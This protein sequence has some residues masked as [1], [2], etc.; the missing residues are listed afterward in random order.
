M[1]LL[2]PTFQVDLRSFCSGMNGLK[3]Q[4]IKDMFDAAGI[5]LGPAPPASYAGERRVLTERYLSTVDWESDEDIF[6]VLR[7]VTITLFAAKT[8]SEHKAGLRELCEKE[9]LR[10]EANRVVLGEQSGAGVKNLIFAANG[11]KPEIVIMDATT[12]DIKITKNAEYCLI[13]DRP[14]PGSLLWSELVAWW[15]ESGNATSDDPDKAEDEFYRRLEESLDSEPEKVLMWQYH[16]TLREKLGS[17]LPALIPQVYLHYDPYTV[18]ARG[19]PGPLVRQRMD[20]LLLLKGGR[21]VVIEI[22]GKQHYSDGDRSSPRLYAKMVT[23]DRRLRLKRYEVFR[24]GGY[25]FMAENKPKSML[26]AFFK[27]LL[28]LYGYAVD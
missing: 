17:D 18:K 14:I 13:Y 7:A 22:D 8:S 20:F 5:K 16:D 4:Q 23:E 24:F 11:Y 21:R 19:S 28:T 9:G 27:D 25:E 26:V 15:I 3:L 12:N 10:I 6:K 2:S 1:G